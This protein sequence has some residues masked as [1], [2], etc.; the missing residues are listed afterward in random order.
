VKPEQV[1]YVETHGTGTSLG[2][3]IEV[4]ALGSV[5]GENR[6]REQPLMIGSV[7]T[8]IGHLEA[9]AGVSG[10]IKV[11]LALQNEEVPPHLHLK[12]P[13]PHI[14]WA[15]LP[16]TV[17]TERRSWPTGNGRRLAGVSSFGF[18]GTNAHVVL[19]EAPVRESAP[20]ERDRPLHLL[21]LS[22]KSEP[23]LQEL[24]ARFS[25][26]LREH[27]TA[28]LADICFTA[29]TGRAHFS[30]RLAV[31][32]KSVTQ[33]SGQLAD[34]TSGQQAADLLSGYVES[35][36]Q[37][38]VA[39]LFTGQ[40]SQYPQM[41]R[42]LFET[43]PTFRRI[44]QECDE[45][46]RPYLE[47]SLLSVLYGEESSLL[48]QTSYTQP[49]LFALEY[50]LSEL[51]RSWGVVPDAVL[52]H[53]VG[54]YVA[55][56]VAGVFTLAEGLKLI[57]A[58]G[59]LMQAVKA[60]G[61]MAAV[62]AEEGRVRAAIAPFT[63]E[64]SIAA[65]NTPGQVVIS[66][67][68]AAVAEVVRS[69][70]GQGVRVEQLRVSHAFHSP[71]MEEMLAEFEQEAEAVRYRAPQIKLISNVTGAEVSSTEVMQAEYWRRHVRAAVQFCKGMETLAAQGGEVFVEVGPSATLIGMGRECV[72][73]GRG[74]WIASMRRG[75]GEWQQLLE[76][77]A[78]FYLQGVEVNWQGVEEDY[79]Q[80]R[81]LVVL[82]SYPFQRRSY[83]IEETKF[84]PNSASS[85]QRRDGKPEHPLL[86]Q[87]LRSALPQVLFESQ[88][89]P[90]SPSFLN[91]HQI[92]GTVVMPA[93]SYL[94]MALAAG[95][96]IYGAGSKVL[97]DVVIHEVMVL[98][99]DHERTV[100][101]ILHPEGERAASF[102]ILSLEEVGEGK[103]GSWVLH[104]TGK[105][106]AGEIDADVPESAEVVQMRCQKEVTGEE[107]YQRIKEAGLQLGPSCRGIEKLWR[108]DG[109]ALA[110]IVLPEMLASKT[111]LYQFHPVLLDAS[112]QL[113]AATLHDDGE[114][115]RSDTYVLAS[116]ER[117]SFYSRPGT[118]LNS[119]AVV[120]TD[121]GVDE[122][123]FVG[124][125][126]LFDEDGQVV[127]EV[128]GLRVKR[129]SREALL[130]AMR[131]DEKGEGLHSGLLLQLEQALP[132]ERLELLAAHV[133]AQVIKVLGLDSADEVDRHRPLNELGLD[134]LMAIELRNALGVAVG[135]NLP[136]TLLF[137][138]PTVETLTKYLATEVLSL[139]LS[140]AL[141]RESVK[142]IDEWAEVSAK[143]EGLPED[144]LAAL[145]AA[146][147][148]AIESEVNPDE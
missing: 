126:K 62:F 93:S 76:G 80:Q 100:Q 142:D 125:I 145:L 90:H 120:R 143:L 2:D 66:G 144:E 50:A 106:R 53:S 37:P 99:E 94:E 134:S 78:R 7:K 128:K 27:P 15:E 81:R 137:D 25:T 68:R 85:F 88:I 9:A 147:L 111:G 116:L 41:G 101:L 132:K 84:Q 83:W 107:F 73:E 87:K 28:S 52:G 59:R 91:D 115:T 55:A 56:C 96:E 48:D 123:K 129:A 12:E 97:E 114:Q 1:S 40:G 75:R 130:R 4:G 57:A 127:A 141:G 44:L 54:E 71:L 113:F 39:F 14:S 31:V 92:Y 105:V 117:F 139:E 6:S 138:Y 64:V 148:E 32:A 46:L 98:T 3:P 131:R 95:T 124:D 118:Q 112:L 17:P 72:S 5:L 135:H 89:S 140:A 61:A 36:G 13:S 30:H 60:E 19:E 119:H 86:G 108:R 69:L 26:H 109:E 42:E 79:K 49:A 104:T 102:Q 10:L 122:R 65:L 34:F 58:R 33:T 21:T 77:L 29:N 51:W 74:E 103:E 16:V 70:A 133:G 8:N 47:H 110:R 67:A 43:Q 20:V 136:S 63:E 22:A 121:N 35:G 38:R 82:P 146:K 24:A 45:L 18:G 11:V 23:A